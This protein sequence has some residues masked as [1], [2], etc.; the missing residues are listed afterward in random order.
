MRP[1][2]A[3]ERQIRREVTRRERVGSRCPRCSLFPIAS[4][5]DADQLAVLPLGDGLL[6]ASTGAELHAVPLDATGARAGD[7]SLIATLPGII[8]QLVHESHMND[9]TS[10]VAIRIGRAFTFGIV[11][12]DPP[13]WTPL[14]QLDTAARVE[15]VDVALVVRG[16][17]AVIVLESDATTAVPLLMRYRLDLVTGELSAGEPLTDGSTRYANPRLGVAQDGSL[18]LLA[19]RLDASAWRLVLATLAD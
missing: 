4:D 17:E 11:R 14:A 1:A 7:A 13:A 16:D 18:A 10:L 6:L 5:F 3:P 15:R 9:V 12:A 8:E 2:A 19:R